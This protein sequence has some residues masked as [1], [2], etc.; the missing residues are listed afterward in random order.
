[1]QERSLTYF[2]EACHGKLAGGRAQA[3]VC[4]VSTDSRTIRN[5]ELFIALVGEKFDGHKFIDAAI[6][7][8]ASAIVVECSRVCESDIEKWSRRIGVVVVENTKTALGNIAARYRKDFNI[9]II[10]VCGSNGKSTTKELIASV[11][12]QR[13]VTHKSPASFNNDIGVPL[14]LLGIEPRHKAAV[15]EVGTNHPGELKPLLDMVVPRYGVLTMIGREHLG[16]FGSLE[17]VAREEGTLA[18]VLPPEGK[19]F[20]CAQGE[21]DNGTAL[22]NHIFNSVLSR[23][24]APVITVG[25]GGTTSNWRARLLKTAIDKTLFYVE[26]PQGDYS[27]EYEVNLPGRHQITNALLAIA[28]GAEF[29][30]TRDEIRS[31]LKNATPPYM[32]M[33]RQRW[34]GALILNDAYNAN[35]DSMKAALQTLSELECE[36]KK[37]AVIGTMAELGNYS[38]TAH[39]EAGELAAKFG[40]NSVIAVGEFARLIAD[41][42]RNAGVGDVFICEDAKS[43]ADRLKTICRSG[44]LVLIKASR[45]AKLEKTLEFLSSE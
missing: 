21:A 7:K 20:V 12:G 40:I 30:L 35:P 45:S 11:L 13:F 36:G 32:R 17:I 25:L 1:M 29:G 24:R 44:D 14:T 31:G 15:I 43:A 28:I 26:F 5:G 16:F 4:G 10:A 9:P 38:E 37:I 22:E 6:Q 34:C 18:E 33:Q 39:K 23:C 19:L 8:G 3:H 41:S 2:V 42:A 27:G